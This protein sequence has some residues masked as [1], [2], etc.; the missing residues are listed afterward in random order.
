MGLE[1][2]P[3][4]SNTCNT[5]PTQWVRVSTR[6]IW[7][8]VSPSLSNHRR[9]LPPSPPNLPAASA[10]A[11]ADRPP[12]PPP[13]SSPPHPPR[14]F[15][16]APPPLQPSRLALPGVGC[17]PPC[18]PSPPTRALLGCFSLACPPPPPHVGVWPA[19]ATLPLAYAPPAKARAYL[20]LSLSWGVILEPSP[21]HRCCGGSLHLGHGDTTLIAANAIVAVAQERNHVA[22]SPGSTNTPR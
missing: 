19:L 22:P 20:L 6:P 9:L 1:T 13:S 4:S 12:P 18:K 14:P 16:A 2:S 17:H 21:T 3:C 7:Y 15:L 8:P 11:M 10:G 5:H